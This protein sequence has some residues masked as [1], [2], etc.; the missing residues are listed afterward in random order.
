MVM[1]ELAQAVAVKAR[2]AGVLGALALALFLFQPAGHARAALVVGG[3]D[4]S[5]GGIDSLQDSGERKLEKIIKKDFSAVTFKF[6][7]SLTTK[8]L[9]KVDVFVMGVAFASTTE[10]TPLTA[11]EQSALLAFVEKGGTLIAF[12][13]NDL[14]FGT[15]SNSVLTPFGMSATGVLDDNQ[16]ASFLNIS[17]PIQSGPFG[18]A[19]QIDMSWPGWFASL[20][21]STELAELQGNNEP[22][23]AYFPAATIS[24]TSGAAIFFS[25]TSPM[26]DSFRTKNDQIAILN[27]IALAH[28]GGN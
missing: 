4:A 21:T 3:F 15:A 14:Q 23:L 28:G 24:Q 17:N 8:F 11:G 27:A 7:N 10:I 18:T 1:F 22:A 16:T 13:D 2:S 25:D 26:N 12:T 6:A 20:G 5:R 9:K 19:T